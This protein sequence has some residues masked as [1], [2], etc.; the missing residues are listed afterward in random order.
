MKNR[1]IIQINN[2]DV[3]YGDTVV[4]KSINLNIKKGEIVC[5]V[6]PS[7]AGKSSLLRHILGEELANNGTV[8]VEDKEVTGPSKTMGF[9]AQNYSIFPNYTALENVTQGIYLNR[10]NLFQNIIYNFLKVFKIKTKNIKDIEE[11]ALECLAMVD[12]DKHA[13]K[14]PYQLSGGQQQRVAIASALVLKP[15][16]LLMD[17]AFSALD[18]E[19]KM[20]LRKSIIQLKEKEDLTIIFVTHDLDGDVPALATRVVAVTRHYDGGD[21]IGAKVAFDSPHPLL[22]EDITLEDKIASSKSAQWIKQ[23]KKECFEPDYKQPQ[24]EFT[25]THIDA[26]RIN[27]DSI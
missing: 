4:L 13:H 21:H 5:F 2:L 22:N 11:K 7:G 16:I 14:Y 8:K 10:F 20:Q 18:P 19:T 15:K 12:M 24:K 6:G 3:Q 27:N 26:T 1:Y 23:M 25:L 9:I 17:E